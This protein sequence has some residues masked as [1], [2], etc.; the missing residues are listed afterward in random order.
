MSSSAPREWEVDIS[1]N[2]PAGVVHYREGQ[3]SASFPWEFVV[4]RTLAMITVGHSSAWNHVVPWAAERR[5]V[6]L[7]RVA[8][9]VL[10]QKAPNCEAVV[11]ETRGCILINPKW[12]AA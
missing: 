7:Q 2:G 9:E 4:G 12:P 8:E 10:R 1:G 6:V 5:E 3:H 11:D